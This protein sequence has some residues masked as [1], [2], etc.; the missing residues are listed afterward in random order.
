M[1]ANDHHI[2][3]LELEPISSEDEDYESTP[4]DY[5]ITTYPAD[6]TLEVL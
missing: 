2:V 1:P 6:Y 5:Q 3:E 4:P